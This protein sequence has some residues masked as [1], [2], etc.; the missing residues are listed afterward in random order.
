MFVG[1][2]KKSLQYNNELAW[3]LI[4]QPQGNLNNGP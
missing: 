3:F 2:M 1:R 4:V